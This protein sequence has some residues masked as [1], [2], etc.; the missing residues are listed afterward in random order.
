MARWQT[1]A[2][3]T[4]FNMNPQYD[5]VWQQLIASF[6]DEDAQFNFPIKYPALQFD[7]GTK[8][9]FYITAGII[10]AGIIV[11]AAIY[12]NKKR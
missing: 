11:A 3:N 1:A 10:S 8:Q 5:N 7:K 6:T 12:A 9:S 2:L 4:V